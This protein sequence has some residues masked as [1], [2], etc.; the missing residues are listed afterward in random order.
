MHR[1]LYMVFVYLSIPVGKCPGLWEQP[2]TVDEVAGISL[3]IQVV[4]L[5]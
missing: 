2:K 5:P 4:V 3:Q 1:H